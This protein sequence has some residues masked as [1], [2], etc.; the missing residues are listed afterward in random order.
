MSDF[1]RDFAAVQMLFQMLFQLWCSPVYPFCGFVSA[2]A[3]TV[4]RSAADESDL[5]KCLAPFCN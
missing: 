4:S 1:A 2:N 5:L 3:L